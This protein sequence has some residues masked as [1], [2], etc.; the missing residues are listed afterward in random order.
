MNFIFART[1]NYYIYISASKQTKIY[2]YVYLHYL[3]E[4]IMQ[5]LNECLCTSTK[6]VWIPIIISVSNSLQIN[7]NGFNIDSLLAIFATSSFLI[8]DFYSNLVMA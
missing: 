6:Q 4:W 7:I 5:F 8:C 2:N 3:F 1:N